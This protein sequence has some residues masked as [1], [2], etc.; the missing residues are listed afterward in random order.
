MTV[1]IFRTCL[2]L[3]AQTFTAQAYRE[4]VA[5]TIGGMCAYDVKKFFRINRTEFIFTKVEEYP[6]EFIVKVYKG[7][8]IMGITSTEK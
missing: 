6:N 1:E 2:N 5:N 3:L 4:V 8:A 7:L